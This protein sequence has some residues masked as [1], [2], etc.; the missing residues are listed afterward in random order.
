MARRAVDRV[1]VT[2]PA[3]E[4]GSRHGITGA[5]MQAVAANDHIL[6]RNRKGRAAS[7]LMIGRDDQGRCLAMPVVPTD[8]PRTWRAITTWFCKSSEAAKLC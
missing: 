7:H 6:A 3:I 8:H 4:K 5:Q 2:Q 1:I